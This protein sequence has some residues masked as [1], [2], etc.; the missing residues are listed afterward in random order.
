MSHPKL[1]FLATTFPV[2]IA[3]VDPATPPVFGKMNVIQMIEHMSDSIRDAYGKNVR[4]LVTPADRLP[5]MKAFVMSEKEFKPNTKSSL[6]GE[7]PEPSKFDTIAEALKEYQ[8]E[9]QAFQNHF[10]GKETS[11]VMNAFF[12]PL[13]Y[14]EWIQLLHKHAVHHLK[15]FGF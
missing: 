1:Q 3:K 9:I 2:E 7:E 13:N 5:A 4:T 15:Q 11:I 8:T 10:A 14:E 6:M 12:G